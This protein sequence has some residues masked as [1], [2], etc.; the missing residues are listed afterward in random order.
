MRRS[1]LK[2]RGRTRRTRRNTK[3]KPRAKKPEGHAEI[4]V[5]E[6]K[7]QLPVSD[8]VLELSVQGFVCFYF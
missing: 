3:T 5:A 7:W 2:K 8:W 6:N 1:F 4:S